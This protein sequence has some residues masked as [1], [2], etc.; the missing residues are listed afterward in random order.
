MREVCFICNEAERMK[1]KK[2]CKIKVTLIYIYI[3]TVANSFL[4]YFDRVSGLQQSCLLNTAINLNK[5][6]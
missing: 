4:K 1:W 5:Y 6:L 2:I 3:L